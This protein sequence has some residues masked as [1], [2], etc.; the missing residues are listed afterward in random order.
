MLI[1]NLV[2]IV[3][4]FYWWPLQFSSGRLSNEPSSFAFLY[5]LYVFLPLLNVPYIWILH[6]RR[7]LTEA[8]GAGPA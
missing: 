5:V 2:A 4:C 1:G 7:R 6:N 8:G 3:F